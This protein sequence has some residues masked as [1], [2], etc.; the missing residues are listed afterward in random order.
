MY[1]GVSDFKKDY[2]PRTNIVKEETGN[3]V[4]DSHSILARWRN[5][6]SQVLN[7]LEVNGVRQTEIHTA[8][9]LVPEPSTFE[10]E[11][12][13]EKLKS[14]KFLSID[15]IPAELIKAVRR[16]IR[17]ETHTFISI[18]NKEEL[19][20]EWK[21]SIIYKKGDKTD[22]SNYRGTFLPTTYKILSKILLSRLTPYAEEIAADYLGGFRSNRSA[23]DHI[24]SIRQTLEKKW[25]YNE[26]VLQLFID[27]KKA[28]DSVTREVLHNILIEF[29][30]PMK[31]IG[32]IKMCLT[33]TYCRVRVG[34]N[35]CDVFS[36]RK[37]LKQ[38]D[39]L[40]PLLFN[41]AFEYA[42]RRVQVNKG[43]LKL[44]GTHPLLVY[45]NEFN[46]L[47]GSVHA[48]K[49]IAEALVV[50]SKEIGLEVKADKTKYMA[51]S[52]D[53]NARRSHSIKT[54]NSSFERLEQ[55]KY[56]GTTLKNQNSIRRN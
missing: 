5:H 46:I 39:A 42:I 41:C 47:G 24:F 17:R 26:A 19:R 55:L 32:L 10:V 9:P 33:E 54:D 43:G 13:I 35:L 53:Q 23:S 21:K 3:L 27:F 44:N 28:F 30:I 49:E 51:M 34:K 25:E 56:L 29:I 14:H 22:C 8:E 50:A 37:D 40:S 36:I 11:L 1:K 16:T 38:G 12:S 45:A 20:E 15:Q 2:Q 48:V 4:A 31:L 18:W 52:R 6:F 7:I